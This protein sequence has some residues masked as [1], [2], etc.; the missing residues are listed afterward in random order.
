MVKNGLIIICFF[1]TSLSAFSVKFSNS[2]NASFPV[3]KG[4]QVHVSNQHG[5]ISII[6]VAS[7]SITIEVLVE[8]DFEILDD[9]AEFFNSIDINLTRRGQKIYASSVLSTKF[10]YF[11]P[12]SI[13]FIIY[14]PDSLVWDITNKFGNVKS[15]RPIFISS[16]NLEYGD[17]HIPSLRTL[18]RDVTNFSLTQCTL[19]TDTL[20]AS[21]IR[22]DGAILNIGIADNLVLRSEF[23]QLNFGELSNSEIMSFTDNIKIEKGTQ[24]NISSSY[25]NLDLNA[26]GGELTTDMSYGRLTI[27]NIGTEAKMLNIN[28]NK[29]QSLLGIAH[30]TNMLINAE[31]KYCD[32]KNTSAIDKFQRIN[33]GFIKTYKGSFGD[34]NQT[35]GILT[36]VSKFEDVEI[37]TDN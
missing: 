6:P 35:P 28:L 20:E 2:H 15:D 1:L 37:R 17:L 19:N 29:V 23:S 18:N 36:I 4:Y 3:N 21:L 11:I 33:D 34:V 8:A 24:L 31:M 32:L 26:P 22:S 9:S 14:T 27:T 30:T 13:D 12:Y 7:D 5:N 16:L 10:D 25:S